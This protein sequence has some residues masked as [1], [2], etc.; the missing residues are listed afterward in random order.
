MAREITDEPAVVV[1]Q[2]AEDRD[3]A[4]RKRVVEHRPPLAFGEPA[5]VVALE[6]MPRFQAESLALLTAFQGLCAL[7]EHVDR[8]PIVAHYVVDPTHQV[9]APGLPAGIIEVNRERKAAPST[10]ESPILVG[11][12][13]EVATERGS[14]LYQPRSIAQGFRQRLRSAKAIETPRQFSE[15]LERVAQMDEE[16]DGM[17][18]HLLS[19][20]QVL[21]RG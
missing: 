9:S 3:T 15:H 4:T 5:D 14:D 16:V 19:L 17:L 6:E 1:G 13:P 8:Q 2:G 7:S 20:G 21:E 11:N 12:G 10:L 18:P